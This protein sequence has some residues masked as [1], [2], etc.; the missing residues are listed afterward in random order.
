MDYF[1]Q[2]EALLSFYRNH[3]QL[4]KLKG[5]FLKHKRV[6]EL[7]ICALHLTVRPVLRKD[8]IREFNCHL[9][10]QRKYNIR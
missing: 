5:V 2:P 9:L 7:A 6:N 3:P 4:L 1:Y 8:I 10:F